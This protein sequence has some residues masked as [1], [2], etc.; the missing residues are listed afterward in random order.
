MP[1]LALQ[2]LKG[3]EGHGKDVVLKRCV[4]YVA[5]SKQNGRS[6]LCLSN[7]GTQKTNLRQKKSILQRVLVL[8]QKRLVVVICCQYINYQRL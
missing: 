1:T 8:F 4:L 2:G 3:K 7:L 6:F 5:Q